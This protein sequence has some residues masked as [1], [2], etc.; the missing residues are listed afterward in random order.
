MQQNRLIGLAWRDHIRFLLE[1]DR[2]MLQ[3]HPAFRRI[4]GI[5]Y[6]G[7]S[8]CLYL[9]NK[10][11]QCC[12]PYSELNIMPARY[13]R[14]AMWDGP[15]YAVSSLPSCIGYVLLRC[16]FSQCL[17]L[18]LIPTQPFCACLKLDVR[19]FLTNSRKHFCLIKLEQYENIYSS[20]R[21]YFCMDDFTY[22]QRWVYSF[23]TTR[24][25]W[26]ASKTKK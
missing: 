17:L 6:A 16:S 3:K 19:K 5:S 21:L 13:L 10:F 2:L 15:R 1:S 4:Y 26:L 8:S 11:T 14:Y 9:C 25:C 20:C 18:L 12:R 24:F 22:Q 23:R 7:H